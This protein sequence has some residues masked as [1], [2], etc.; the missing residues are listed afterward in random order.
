MPTQPTPFQNPYECEPDHRRPAIGG[1]A[2]GAGVAAVL[3]AAGLGGVAHADPEPFGGADPVFGLS[4]GDNL[5]SGPGASGTFSDPGSFAADA[6]FSSPGNSSSQFT[7][8]TSAATS[9]P[10]STA[11]VPDPGGSSNVPEPRTAPDL[12]TSPAGGEA[13]GGTGPGA[14]GSDP[15]VTV[16]PLDPVAVAG[17]EGLLAAVN[18]GV[19][20]LTDVPTTAVVGEAIELATSD[21]GSAG[22]VGTGGAGSVGTPGEGE[23]GPE[24]FV[25][26]TL[27]E[28]VSN[29]DWAAAVLDTDAAGADL[30]TAGGA[31]AGDRS[32]LAG[33]G[34]NAVPS[35]EP[36]LGQNV[37][38]EVAR[39]GDGDT[40]NVTN[41]TTTGNLGPLLEGAGTEPAIAYTDTATTAE[42]D[43][44]LAPAGGTDPGPLQVREGAVQ[45]PADE[46]P[47]APEFA[48]TRPET[49]ALL[50]ELFVPPSGAGA[51]L[52]LGL[53]DPATQLGEPTNPAD[54]GR[55][56]FPPLASLSEAAGS[57][58]A[59]VTPLVP[60]SSGAN[61]LSDDTEFTFTPLPSLSEAIGPG[62]VAPTDSIF[63]ETGS[64]ADDVQ[65]TFTPVP[66]LSDP[67]GSGTET[68][69][70]GPS[71]LFGGRPTAPGSRLSTAVP[72]LALADP[73]AAGSAT[74]GG[75]RLAT[76]GA[77]VAEGP[78]VFSTGFG[79]GV[80]NSARAA[81]VP[82]SEL[83]GPVDRRLVG[84]DSGPGVVRTADGSAGRSA[85]SGD[86]PP[87]GAGRTPTSYLSPIVPPESATPLYV[88]LGALAG[89]PITATLLPK[90]TFGTTFPPQI[91]AS[92]FDALIGGGLS[93]IKPTG[94]R[95]IDAFAQAGIAS[96][97]AVGSNEALKRIDRRLPSL[98]TENDARWLGRNMPGGVRVTPP[99]RSPLA[100]STPLAAPV[101]A[102]LPFSATAA[103]LA[104]TNFQER[105]GICQ[106]SASDVNNFNYYCG[107]LMDA[108]ALGVGI[109]GPI[110]VGNF[111]ERA[112]QAARGL[113]QRPTV[114]GVLRDTAL[115]PLIVGTQALGTKIL[116]KAPPNRDGVYDTLR[117]GAQFVSDAAAGVGNVVNGPTD[118]TDGAGVNLG[119]GYVNGVL[120]LGS[121]VFEAVGNS[122]DPVR[123]VR[124]LGRQLQGGT[125]EPLIS[126]AGSAEADR[127][128][129]EASRALRT[130]LRQTPTTGPGAAFSTVANT[131]DGIGDAIIGAGQFVVSPVFGSADATNSL[132]ESGAAFSRAGNSLGVASR[133]TTRVAGNIGRGGLN[134]LQHGDTRGRTRSGNPWCSDTVTS[135]CIR[136]GSEKPNNPNS[137]GELVTGRAVPGSPYYA[138]ARRRGLAG[139]ATPANPVAYQRC[140]ADGRCGVREV[141]PLY[142][143]DGSSS[144]GNQLGTFVRNVSNPTYLPRQLSN[145]VNN[146]INSF[147]ARPVETILRGATMFLR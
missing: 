138:E 3:A 84:A 39:P 85:T 147:R 73:V 28:Q 72:G 94:V 50:D 113:A 58:T 110:A 2:M 47:T 29:E 16:T 37:D 62:T 127:R 52:Q 63:S 88:L 86:N 118:R 23:L 48:F 30:G 77:A 135:G 92:S 43:R 107:A 12:N 60:T 9:P 13:T 104:S 120:A 35:S 78:T 34:E 80:V 83:Q 89:P 108:G 140:V 103:T 31:P 132:Q 141:G 57:G 19:M 137:M 40:L 111:L 102:A 17:G 105:T 131:F 64:S 97:V 15:S 8:D 27:D 66:S 79:E 128:L 109:Q 93:G 32:V 7:V 56:G 98:R 91:R 53:T 68:F 75:A 116:T 11:N 119:R 145:V 67:I 42:L 121:P 10:D 49:T 1:L 130:G 87:G 59:A 6:A 25:V 65:F 18:S 95:E 44:L 106:A 21:P 14:T 51:G 70:P 136:P 142:V 82:I 134:L 24:E 123:A 114:A 129:E 55:F 101:L 115:I 144:P 126:R 133:E 117:G 76:G 125:T 36:V 69:E 26:L 143:G 122:V 100:F 74:P 33:T 41:P 71:T 81:G 45:P 124:N 54:D 96:A 99:A 146:A 20:G 90:P 61:G 112:G 4:G 139:P 22:E 5:S 38:T 46:V